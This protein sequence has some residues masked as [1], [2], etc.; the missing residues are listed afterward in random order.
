MQKIT[1]GDEMD[2]LDSASEDG[3]MAADF[4]DTQSRAS[5]SS[6][7]DWNDKMELEKYCKKQ[8]KLQE[9]V[10]FRPSQY[11]GAVHVE[12]LQDGVED[13]RIDGKLYSELMP[14]V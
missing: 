11:F 9:E 4:E 10:G 14:C 7:I 2:F 12:E 5:L 1:Q 6:H 3:S 13:S 8:K